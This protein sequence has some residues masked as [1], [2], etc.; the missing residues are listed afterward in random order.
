M[1]KQFLTK[2]TK[3]TI[4]E[5]VTNIPAGL[6]ATEKV[7]KESGKFNDDAM[8]DV[9]SKL[10]KVYDF[11]KGEENALK[12]PPKT[13][14]NN[15]EDEYET[16]AYGSGK[17]SSLKYDNEDTEV[18]EMFDKRVEDLNDT[19]EYDKNFGTHDG[20]G[21]GKKENTFKKLKDSSEKFKKHKYEK[22]DEYQKTPRVRTTNESTIKRLTYK[23][24]F[25]DEKHALTLIPE[26]YKVEN[27]IFILTDGDQSY[28]VRW[29]GN[30]TLGEGII[31][32]SKNNTL[33]ESEKEKMK[34][35][36]EYKSSKTLG[37]TND[38][39]T[40]EEQMKKMMNILRKK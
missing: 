29:E 31:L 10:S 4:K 39:I 19:S 12:N 11:D 20:F 32:L 36:L 34:Q 16:E 38:I 14:R 15:V 35:L 25:K 2:N 23:T 1:K 22:P 30:N 18:F 26:G 6:T 33:I 7:Q 17:M 5:A 37:K 28:K 24:K 13:N 27:N 9:K 8:K 40:E 21:Q 3:I